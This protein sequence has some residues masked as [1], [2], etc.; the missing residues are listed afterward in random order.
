[1]INCSNCNKKRKY[2]ITCNSCELP[3]CRTCSEKHLLHSTKDNVSNHCIK[4]G[5]KW[6]L[7][8]LH[9]NGLLTETF[10]ISYMDLAAK[11]LDEIEED[12]NKI[13]EQETYIN[14]WSEQLTDLSPNNNESSMQELYLNKFKVI[15]MNPDGSCFYHCLLYACKNIPEFQ[16]LLNNY[17]KI[18]KI[19]DMQTN[20]NNV[21]IL[22][23]ALSQNVSLED[24]EQYKIFQDAE[25]YYSKCENI[26][27]FKQLI[28][29]PTEYINDVTIAIFMR[30]MKYEIGLYIYSNNLLVSPYEYRNKKYNIF[31]R[32]EGEHYD[33]LSINDTVILTKDHN[34]LLELP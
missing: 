22:R 17:S 4:C 9:A 26:E 23:F 1:M 12:M 33:V 19:F 24:Y 34:L 8:Q 15:K 21:S 3:I 16:Q 28:M 27:D 14:D 30:L 6:D 2:I 13:E 10:I 5:E 7:L 18:S 20:K 25:V 29:I 32:L 31:L 11:L